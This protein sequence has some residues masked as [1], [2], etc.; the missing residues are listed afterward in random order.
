[1][2]AIINFFISVF[3][4]FFG[5]KNVEVEQAVSIPEQVKAKKHHFPSLTKKKKPAQSYNS[6]LERARAES[7]RAKSRGRRAHAFGGFRERNQQAIFIPK[8]H[9]IHSYRFEQRLVNAR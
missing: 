9:T 7:A 3:N 2:K 5:K 1:M 4:Y 6:S 8:Q